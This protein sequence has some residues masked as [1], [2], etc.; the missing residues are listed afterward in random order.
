MAGPD[1][2]YYDD[3]IPGFFGKVQAIVRFFENPCDAPWFV[4]ME[5]LNAPLGHMAL[6]LLSFGM[7]DIVRGY[8]R[9]K[10]LNRGN[11]RD[12]KGGRGKGRGGIP[13][14]GEMISEW[15]PAADQMK[16]RQVTDGVK[17]LW[18]L[19]GVIQRGLWWW[20]AADLLTDGLFIWTSLINKS[21]YCSLDRSRGAAGYGPDAGSAHPISGWVAAGPFDDMYLHDGI[22]INHST[23][24]VGPGA[25]GVVAA[26]NIQAPLD[27][28]ASYQLRWHHADERG[29]WDHYGDVK[30]FGFGQTV[31]AIHSSTIY[32]PGGAGIEALATGGAVVGKGGWVWAR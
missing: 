27:R 29:L 13:E 22:T 24:H 5:T 17:H 28:M 12:K 31:G 20:F 26:V 9:P 21:E 3:H 14:V 25:W 32:G 11:K 10:G 19:D 1:S 4:Y 15:L 8:A 30:E 6:G 18:V 2:F 23:V 16:N 7:D